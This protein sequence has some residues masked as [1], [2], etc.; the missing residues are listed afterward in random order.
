M[1]V[2]LDGA[3]HN[4]RERYAQARPRSAAL[5]ERARAVLPGGNT[6]SVFR[7]LRAAP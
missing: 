3:L 5:A 4:A 1:L 6:R 2:L 7:V